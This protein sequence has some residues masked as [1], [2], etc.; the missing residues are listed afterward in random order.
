[1]KKTKKTRRRNRP[2]PKRKIDSRMSRKL[3]ALFIGVILVF[4]ALAVDITYVNAT[5][6][7]KYERQVL[8]Q[9]QQSYDSRT[10]PY[11]RG[12]ITD[13]NG[14]ILATSE[15]VYNVILDCKVTNTIVTKNKV[16]TTPYVEPTVSALVNVLGL[17]ESMIR[18]KLTNENTKDSQ[19]QILVKQISIDEKKA[20]EAYV[21]E[22]A[23]IAS[24]DLTEKEQEI[25]AER[26]NIKGVWFEEDYKRVYPLKS[27][28]CD[29]IG[30][31]YTGN[32][33]DWGIEGYYSSVLNGVNGRQFGYY[34]E[35]ADIEQTIIEPTAGNNVVSTID[36]NVQQIIRTAIENFNARINTGGDGTDASEE[37]RRVKGAKN[38]GVIVMDP[39]SGEILG[40]DSSDW[41]DLNEPRNLHLFYSDEEIEAMDNSDMMDALNAIW[42]NYC[43][44]DAYEPGSTA[45]PMNVAAAY[46]CD[47][48]DDDS[49]FVCDGIKKVADRE[50]KCSIY[51]SGH[52]TESPGDALK[53]SCNDALMQIAELL[54]KEDFL[55]YQ[56]IY[57]FGSRTG[58]DLPGEAYGLIHTDETMGVTELATSSF[59]QGY[60]V[61]MIQQAAA[62]ASVIN[63]GYYYQPHVMKSIT[64]ANGAVV[65]EYEAKV[66]RQTISSDLSEKMRGFLQT[67]VREGTG[68][69]AKVAGYTMGGKT[70]TAQKYPRGNGKYLV[71]FLGFAPVENP[72]V[73]VYVVIDEP[74]VEE[75]ANS[76]LAQEVAKEIFAE[77]LPYM[78]L[79][80]DDTDIET[81]EGSEVGT[82]DENVPDPPSADEDDSVQNGGNNLQTD[83]ITNEQAEYTNE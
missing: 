79:F 59:G 65:E 75:Q 45:K 52:G 36:V 4:V 32:T 37:D 21:D 46:A 73:V 26:A 82:E 1:M 8:S 40:M 44:S 33:A 41:Y 15:K 10:I 72:Q 16:E 78:N 76:V 71:S 43:I 83:G 29:L 80:P 69:S 54:G 28:A 81:S 13:R 63:G 77:I 20:F 18:D 2:L 3:V 38:I 50:I 70:G 55:R 35:D 25:K 60:T 31:T 19:Y 67:A 68:K 57:G 53:N 22:Y 49:T 51:P 9:T 64:D 42:R 66:L 30:F 58:I 47:V 5:K 17:D 11:K 14:T 23:D 12:D 27:L 62:F 61:T 6:G 48:I 39:N 34:N 24:K 74:N 56:E 7:E